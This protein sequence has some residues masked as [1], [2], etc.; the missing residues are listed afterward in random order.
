MYRNR[1]L[2][3]Q[4]SFLKTAP[5]QYV[6]R[7][8]I[9]DRSGEYIRGWGKQTLICG[10]KRALE[11]ARERLTD[12][13]KNAHI[14]WEEHLFSG[15]CCDENIKR[16]IEKIKK[17]RTN[18]VI[19]VGGGKCLDSAKAAAGACTVPI[20]CIP[21]IAATCSAT[22]AQSVVYSKNGIFERVIFLSSNP[23]LV[24]VDP[25]IIA[26]A[27]VIYLQAGILDSLAKWY[28]GRAVFKGI[29]NP[30]IYTSSAMCLSGLLHDEMKKKS[31]RAIE[32]VKENR[33][34]ESLIHVIDLII[35]LTGVIQGMG[36]ATLRGG[37][38]HAVYNGLT[39][40]EESHA[41]LHGIKVGYGIVVQLIL[42]RVSQKEL[43]EVVQFFRKL[44][45]EPSLKGLNL[46]IKEDDTLKIAEKAANDPYIGKMP[47]LVK[48]EM[49]LSAIEKLENIIDRL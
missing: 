16:I 15:E 34:D 43:K 37:I 20:V 2:D 9:L 46:V 3:P 27:P 19:G 38:A 40:L 14:A 12:S 22:T 31:I 32:L 6:N 49:I 36:L 33:V 48:K 24:L 47:F 8:G 23:Q 13:L 26:N 41:L 28:E 42:E 29:K 45:F 35:Y 30:D 25:T 21:T 17:Y 5:I 11:A 18:I 44:D 4:T 10:G 39:V 1:C 7:T